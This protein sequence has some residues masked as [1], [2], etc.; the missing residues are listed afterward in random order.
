MAAWTDS[1]TV[2]AL[3][4]AV[5]DLSI[6]VDSVRATGSH[7]VA[8]ASDSAHPI[9]VR[10]LESMP[11]GFVAVVTHP[12]FAFVW[13]AV[14]GLV[15][16]AAGR[17]YEFW[18]D[19]NRKNDARWTS[20]RLTRRYMLLA[21]GQIL[22]LVKRFEDPNGRLAEAHVAVVLRTVGDFDEIKARMIALEDDEV[23][24]A[25]FQWNVV[26]TDDL[27]EVRDRLTMEPIAYIR[28][29]GLTAPLKVRDIS[30]MAALRMDAE[31][32]S[33]VIAQLQPHLSL[34]RTKRRRGSKS[35]GDGKAAGT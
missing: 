30:I 29:Y 17:I 35:P 22:E 7:V 2:E 13:S 23:E 3:K 18:N 4:S 28:K 25:I 31:R 19:Q 21:Q 24:E 10:Q 14:V 26:A 11:N 9:L 20:A 32:A 12:G 5:R 33:D 16:F 1:A 8:I 6:A 15:A 34:R 27:L